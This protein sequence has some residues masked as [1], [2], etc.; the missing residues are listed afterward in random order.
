MYENVRAETP[1]Q[2]K[3]KILEGNGWGYD[4]VHDV[5]VMRQCE[6]GLDN[7]LDEKR[8]GGCGKSL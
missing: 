7:D 3:A 1:D 2:A 5:E 8:C 4:D 6:C